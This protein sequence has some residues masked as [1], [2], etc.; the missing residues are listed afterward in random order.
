MCIFKY[1]INLIYLQNTAS[2][3]KNN[4]V[5]LKEEL[6]NAKDRLNSLSSI[7]NYYM[8]ELDA[9]NKEV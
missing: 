5:N 9:K 7:V 3:N 1:E 8:E 2:N 6:A 4:R